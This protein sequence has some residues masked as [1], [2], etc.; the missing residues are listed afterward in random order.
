MKRLPCS[1]W[2]DER[3]R[4][5]LASILLV[6]TVVVLVGGV[7]AYMRDGG[8]TAVISAF[9]RV[10]QR[11]ADCMYEAVGC[12]GQVPAGRVLGEESNVPEGR[13]LDGN[14]RGGAATGSGKPKP[15]SLWDRIT[16]A[17]SKVGDV[18]SSLVDSTVEKA[19]NV[20]DK[21]KEVVDGG[22]DVLE[23]GFDYA[24]AGWSKLTT[25][26]SNWWSTRSNLV[27]GLIVGVG[28][29]AVMI[30]GLVLAPIAVPA[31]VLIGTGLGAVMGGALYGYS[32]GAVGQFSLLHAIGFSAVGG[33]LGGLVGLVSPGVS[34][35]Q[36]FWGG[37]EAVAWR[38]AVDLSKGNLSSWTAYAKV[39]AI[40]FVVQGVAA[41]LATKTFAPPGWYTKWTGLFRHRVA[42]WSL[43][44]IGYHVS[45]ADR[46]WWQ[47]LHL[48][49]KPGTW[50]YSLTGHRRFATRVA[51]WV[52][53]LSIAK[54]LPSLGRK[55]IERDIKE[56]I[57]QHRDTSH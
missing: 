26:V 47:V 27:K 33:V 11:Q 49:A 32:I 44:R 53:G 7:F 9:K 28:V 16:G 21:G 52:S 15:A 5:A 25:R 42:N 40:G 12:T 35:A 38:L 36:G 10:E 20:V 6:L 1:L 43:G 46:P 39:F 30:A 50:L 54:L 18:V 22:I 55:I 19:K 17:A 4:A 41:S 23:S 2:K 51:T 45:R 34:V 48:L 56:G 13:A 14:A 24:K 3:G 8:A 57:Q 37:A 31:L 29:G